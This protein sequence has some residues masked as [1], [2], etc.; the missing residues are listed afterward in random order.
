[1]KRAIIFVLIITLVFFSISP[2]RIFIAYS[3]PQVGVKSGDWMKYDV[4]TEERNWTGWIRFDIYEV[5]GT[6]MKFNM[7]M[8]SESFGYT[9]TTGQFNMSEME[10]HTAYPNDVIETFVIPANLKPG[11][12]FRYYDLG[13]ITIA[14]ETSGTYLGASRSVIYATYTPP[15]GIPSEASRVDYKWD[16]TTGVV[17]E[18][19]ALYPDGKTTTGKIADTNIWQPQQGTDPYVLY[20]MA[21]VVTVIVLVAI[22]FAVRRKKKT[23]ETAPAASEIHNEG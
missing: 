10:A 5:E 7:T 2:L 20:A 6:L 12:T 22:L 11:D 9:Y 8:Y 19:S 15:S 3:E 16:K 14:G 13:S 17:L 21:T 23:A 1:V 18:Y 4:V